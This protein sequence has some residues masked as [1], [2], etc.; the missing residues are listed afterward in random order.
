[1]PPYLVAE[2]FIS[3]LQRLESCRNQVLLPIEPCRSAGND[4][5]VD[6]DGT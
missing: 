6:V 3:G 4:V 2:H 1:M 5:P